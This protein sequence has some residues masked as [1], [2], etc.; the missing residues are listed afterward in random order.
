MPVSIL[1]KRNRIR[2]ALFIAAMTFIVSCGY[3][4][5][6]SSSLPFDSITIKPVENRTYEPGLEER[7]HNSL[8]T[9]FTN[10]GID[11]KLSGGEAVLETVITSFQLGA[12]GAVDET[13]K[14]QELIM[15]ADI[16]FIDN[17]SVMRFEG[18]QSP[19][20]ISFQ[21]T[22]TVNQ[23]AAEKERAADKATKEIAKEIVGRIILNYAK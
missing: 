6:G 19:I 16:S 8:S 17:G 12:V 22:G 3:Q 15:K 5:I 1:K 23:S 18:I 2:L 13:I 9:E 11:V 14:E 20:K 4:I 21:S 10:Q 7:L